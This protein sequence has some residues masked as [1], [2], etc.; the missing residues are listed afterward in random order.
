[1]LALFAYARRLAPA[2]GLAL[3]AVLLAWWARPAAAQGSIVF[4]ATPAPAYEFGKTITFTVTV[5]SDS[6]L[7]RL[8]LHLAAPDGTQQ[9][10]TD[11]PF[12]P[13]APTTASVQVDLAQQPL[14]PFAALTYWSM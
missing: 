4:L 2:A 6:P 12:E 13:D 7:S 10:W 1:M 9:Q 5:A 8:E 3:T 14:V 11:I